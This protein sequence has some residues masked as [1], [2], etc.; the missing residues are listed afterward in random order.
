MYSL[1]QS[2]CEAC[3]PGACMGM[4]VRACVCVCVDLA[5]A[6]LGKSAQSMNVMHL[7]SA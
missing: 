5:L 3:Q 6:K 2:R 1:F 4:C 7:T